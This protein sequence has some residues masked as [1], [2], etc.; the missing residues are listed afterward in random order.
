MVVATLALGIGA[1]TALFNYLCLLFWERFEAPEAHRLVWLQSGSPERPGRGVSYPDL[2]DYQVHN[3]MLAPL[4]GMRIAAASIRSDDTE[5]FAPDA[6]TIFAWGNLVSGEFFPL[7][8]AKP[9][10]GRLIQPSDDRPEA[11]PVIVLSHLF[12]SRHF[13][14]D[15]GIVGRTVVL[16]GR[17]PFTVVGV[18]PRGFQSL[19]VPGAFYIPLAKSLE[20]SPGLEER[21][22]RVITAIGRLRPGVTR[23]RA[24][25]AFNAVAHGLDERYPISKS[26]LVTLRKVNG[27]ADDGDLLAVNARILAAVVAFFLLLAC[28]N[29][30]NLFMARAL[31]R[32]RDLAVHA[33]LGA[34]RWHLARRLMTESVV[35]ALA[36]AALG[37]I[38]AYAGLRVLEQHL[39]SVPVGFGN[40]AE[41]A[42][43]LT[44]DSRTLIF[45][46]LASIVAALLF[47]LG[48]ALKMLRADLVTPLKSE[49]AGS[50]GGHKQ[51]SR[52]LLVSVQVA[53]S[54]VLLL[55][56]GLLVQTL[57]GVRQ[58]DPGFETR[59]LLLA[60][61]FFPIHDGTDDTGIHE[62]VTVYR[63]LLDRL[64]AL[65]G[66]RAA[67]VAQ[68]PPLYFGGA[69][70]PVT[71]PDHEETVRV[72][73]SI[74]GPG[75]FE[76]L[77]IPLLAGRGFDRRDH[78]DS[79]RVAVVNETMAEL[80]VT[81]DGA[82]ADASAAI[83]RQIILEQ[84]APGEKGTALEVVGIVADTRYQSLK[85]PPEALFYASYEQLF[86][87]RL[88][89][90]MRT[91]GAMAATASAVRTTLRENY[92][93][94]SVI[95]LV[96]FSEHVRRSL[97]EEKINSD[98][99]GTVA[100]L[101]LA[102]AMLGVASVNG[103][104][105][106][107]RVREIGIRM[108]LG[109]TSRDAFRL[110]LREALTWVG[111]GVVVGW[112]AALASGR[113]LANMLYGVG[114]HDP[115]T[116]LTVPLVLVAVAV[117]ATWL[118]ARRAARVDP[119]VALRDE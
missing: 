114:T 17:L 35:L 27:W 119:S 16:D 79:T 112:L 3:E 88:T 101:G 36:G 93:E 110:V 91:S 19:G 56:A 115:R 68:R 1:N 65:P 102:L 31:A 94:L 113:V 75:Y 15:P 83:G 33:A 106:R 9:T 58:A 118:P 2:L 45:G 90:M 22:R 98:V 38:P 51:W 55:G 18:A 80:L 66:V 96:P 73:Q 42:Y 95:D 24:E 32:R 63:D 47:G 89:F 29:V 116:F 103:Y 34:S 13:G 81:D 92:P 30:A 44:I 108:A 72:D 25:A 69:R 117:I 11:T 84:G 23:E 41:E 105:V 104:S 53:L 67:S 61:I 39:R 85:K 48:P 60:A 74:V 77:G 4:A 40:W 78:H 70:I 43:V 6:A 57:A 109:A 111:A 59:D 37:L 87:R 12:W 26:R 62:R 46:V 21:E 14:A 107:R 52:H 10:I 50:R 54:V 82:P 7:F 49:G 99:A 76:T 20:M 97:F 28:A 86:R 100:I 8:A 64:R 5:I 71:L